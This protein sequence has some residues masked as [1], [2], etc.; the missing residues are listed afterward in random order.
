MPVWSFVHSINVHSI[1]VHSINVHS[2]NVHSKQLKLN[3]P[4]IS[5]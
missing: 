3:L 4:S 5:A 2:I 1:N